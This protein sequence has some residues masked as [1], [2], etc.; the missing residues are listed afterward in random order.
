MDDSIQ[1]GLRLRDY[2]LI[3]RLAL[4]GMAEVWRARETS[5]DQPV[6]IKM[7]LPH[8]AE[9]PEFRQMFAAEAKLAPSLVHPN[10][11]RCFE[12]GVAEGRHFIALEFVSGRT[13]RQLQ[14]RLWEQH[15][16]LP[17][18]LVLRVALDVC[19]ALDYAHERRDAEGR[20]LGIVHRDITPENVMSDFSGVTKVLDF[21]V[22][23]GSDELTP[24]GGSRIKGKLAYL[25]PEQIVVERHIPVD[26]RTDVYAVGAVLYELLTGVQPFRAANDMALLLKIPREMPTPP[27]VIA[28]WVPSRLSAVVMKAL[29][30]S[31]VDRHQSAAELS[32]ELGACLQ[33]EG[34]DATERLVADLMKTYFGDNGR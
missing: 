21:G 18:W 17:R 15:K 14:E 25:S 30:K 8:L 13:V 6:V 3:E 32:E 34:I 4:G 29:S 20:S 9:E 7:I 19:L 33:L 5:A 12:L 24:P 10:I 27:S 11:V 2:Q 26:R 1:P 22:A 16:L 23:K 28:P 31:K